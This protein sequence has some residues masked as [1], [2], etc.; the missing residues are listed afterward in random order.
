MDPE[1]GDRPLRDRRAPRGRAGG[2]S[3]ATREVDAIIRFSSTRHLQHE[4]LALAVGGDEGDAVAD[5]VLRP[6]VARPCGRATSIVPCA[7]SQAEDR[8]EQLAAARTD[9]AREADDLARARR[10]GRPSRARPGSTAGGPRSTGPG[11]RRARAPAG[12]VPRRARGRPSARSAAAGRTRRAGPPP[13]VCPSRR[14]VTRSASSKISLSRCE[15]KITATPS[16]RRRRTTRE[17]R[18]D[19]VVGERARR[20][21]EDQDPRVDR[22]GPCD[23]DHLLLVGPQPPDRQRRVEVEAE[24]RRAPRGACGA[25]R[26]Q[27]MKPRARDHPVAEEHVLGD[28]EV[29]RER[30]LLGHGRDSAAAAPPSGCGR[31]IGVPP[32]M[33]APLS[34]CTCPERIFSSVDLPE[35]FSPTSTCTSP[36]R[37]CEVRPAQCVDAAVALVHVR[38]RGGSR[39]LT[40]EA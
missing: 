29:G 19:L 16:S 24:P 37:T 4:P 8:L 14:T 39:L 15:T 27:S 17:Q 12:R 2:V 33:I 28:R 11:V 23:L 26:R 36:G 25:C 10:R 1:L 38:R 18:L 22:E 32:S 20:L 5:R 40:L 21:V 3:R 31:C 9:E 6:A 35:P 7:L 13:T 30:R 34:G